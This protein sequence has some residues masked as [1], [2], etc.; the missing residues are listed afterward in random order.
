[1]TTSLSPDES[2]SEHSQDMLQTVSSFQLHSAGS[3]RGRR[4]PLRL[5]ER[6]VSEGI[7]THEQ[8]QS[9]LIQQS[10]GQR[11]GEALV[12]MGLL[13]ESDLLPFLADQVGVPHVQLR[14]GL[15]DPAAAVLIPK[16]LA[17]ACHA[18]ALFK[19]HQVLTVAMAEP[20]NLE[21]I[22]RLE[23]ATGLHVRPVLALQGP[24]H[25][26]LERVYGDGFQVDSITAEMEQDAVALGDEA[27]QIDLE[28]MAEGGESSPIINLVNY[29]L[30][31]AV[32]QRAS[33][34]HIEAGSQH[35]T[36]RYRVDGILR[37]VIR[38]RKEYHAAMV[39]RLK[40]MGKMDIAEHRLPQDGRIHIVVDQRPIDLRISTLPTVLGEKVV[41][42]ILDR[43]SITFRLEELGIPDRQMKTLSSLI[44]RPNG[45]LLVTGPTGSGKTTTLYSILELLKSVERNIVTVEDPVEYRL[46]LINQVHVST[47]ANM[48]FARALRAIL[49]QDP[50]IIMIGEIRDL[51]TAEIAVQAALTGH[52]VLSTLHTNDS[53][54]AIPRLIDMGVAPFK[55]AASLIGVVAQRLARKICPHCG[56]T[57]Y[58]SPMTL[59]AIRYAGDRNRQFTRGAGCDK[60]YDT[61]FKGRVGIYELLEVNREMRDLIARGGS[62]SEL[63]S[64]ALSQGFRTLG[65]QAIEMAEQGTTSLDEIMRVAVFD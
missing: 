26:L 30:L 3:T 62:S 14:E 1:M 50:D 16:P 52:L 60:C 43:A 47:A 28:T 13:A 41:L 49:R 48:S 35:S 17:E 55:I 58:P 64:L 2:T 40:V 56:T 4:G 45:L 9:A 22:D 12:D 11:L 31:Q 29:V 42:R 24:I 53:P 18:L 23:R 39:S 51:E 32:R 27:V 33:D 5:G 61:G 7:L 46:D 38:P 20:Q 25:D 57:Y 10:T 36:V 15:I 37:E 63:R 44:S 65:E 54:G 19:V 6:L 59:D 21:S 34:I 8:L